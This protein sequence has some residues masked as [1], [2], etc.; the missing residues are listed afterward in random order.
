MCDM[1]ERGK[2]RVVVSLPLLLCEIKLAKS[3]SE[4]KR[5]IMQGAVS[6]DGTKIKIE[7]ESEIMTSGVVIK[8]GSI[9]KVGKSRFIRVIDTGEL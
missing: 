8:S 1:W 9:V 7:K 3:R 2:D 5:L 6:I 4:A